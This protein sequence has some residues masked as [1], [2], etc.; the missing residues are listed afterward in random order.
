MKLFFVGA[1]LAIAGCNNADKTENANMSGAYKMLSQSY[2]TAKLDTTTTS[3]QQLKIYTA[4]YMMYANFNPG[5]SNGGF[6]IG[7]YAADKDTVTENVFY[8]GSDSTKNDSLRSFKLTIEKITKGYKQV[9]PDV[10][11]GTDHFKLT[12]EYE[13]VSTATTSPL[14]GAWKLVKAYTIKGADS[15][16]DKITQFK[17]YGAGHFIFGHTYSDSLNRPHTG[18][19]YGTFAMTGTNKSKETVTVSTYASVR[20]QVVDVDIE[21]KGADEYKQV[22][23]MKDGTKLAEE[24]QRL[25]K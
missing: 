8:T 24:Y 5:D 6:G 11:F 16:P 12:E 20:G 9:I 19:G 21:L 1:L 14:D 3:L 23:V 15:L 17:V 18:M 13:T 7:T 22:I 10:T 4:D 25:K 2:K